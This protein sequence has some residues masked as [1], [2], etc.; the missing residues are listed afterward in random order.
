MAEATDDETEVRTGT[1][2]RV[3]VGAPW[4]AFAQY[5][6]SL[7]SSLYAL[8]T[9][10]TSVSRLRHPSQSWTTP[11]PD[12]H[13]QAADAYVSRYQVAGSRFSWPAKLI[14]PV[15]FR[16]GG[17]P[18]GAGPLRGGSAQEARR[19]ETLEQVGQEERSWDRD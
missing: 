9:H 8:A 13:R 4:V 6:N 15:T 18:V 12:R 10:P 17:T 3:V 5:P 14:A 11:M 1:A 19:D 2:E 7:Q 16:Y